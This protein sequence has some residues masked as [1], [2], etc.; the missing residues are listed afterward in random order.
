MIALLLNK[1]ASKV[2][3]STFSLS[4][5]IFN[6]QRLVFSGEKAAFVS[7]FK[8]DILKKIPTIELEMRS[9]GIDTS[10]FLLKDD[11]VE[12][13]PFVWSN[14]PWQLTGLKFFEGYVDIK[15][16]IFKHGDLLLNNVSLQGDLKHRLF[17]IKD[18]KAEFG[19]G[20][21][22]GDLSIDISDN[23]TMATSLKLSNIEVKPFADALGIPTE[24]T[25]IV[26]TA[27]ALKTSGKSFYEWVKNAKGN[28]KFIAANV[29]VRPFDIHQVVMS[30]AKL[31]SVIDMQN[32]ITKS[33]EEG[34]TIFNS[35]Q[36]NIV[37]DSGVA[38]LQNVSFAS[39]YT[40]GILAGRINLFNFMSNHALR[41][42]FSPRRGDRV[43]LEMNL[44]GPFGHLERTL[45][46][47]KLDHYITSKAGN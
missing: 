1:S 25:G 11:S 21:I 8:L 45:D 16:S 7:R 47:R 31:Y 41:F 18:A 32:I 4:P 12:N 3:S 46:T 2:I 19:K 17:Q 34:V 35:A 27:G 30:A 13:K 26:N 9:S 20:S 14:E 44:K 15:S 38:Q 40:S 22:N 29:V 43:T 24:M 5:G 42:L 36:G 23:A 37:I 33:M 10:A 28:V 39:K 6:L